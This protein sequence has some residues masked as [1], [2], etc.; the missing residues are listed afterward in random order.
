MS[1]PI[2]FEKSI[3]SKENK[4]YNFLVHLIF[5]KNNETKV[6]NKNNTYNNYVIVYPIHSLICLLFFK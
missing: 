3:L 2:F 5:Q 1:N 6:S 4:M